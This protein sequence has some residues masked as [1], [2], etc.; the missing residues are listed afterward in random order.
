MKSITVPHSIGDFTIPRPEPKSAD[1][2]P[3]RK[4]LRKYIKDATR[5]NS[6]SS[7]PGREKVIQT[8]LNRHKRY[9]LACILGTSDSLFSDDD[10][11]LLPEVL[12]L[13]G[14]EHG[15]NGLYQLL[16]EVVPYLMSSSSA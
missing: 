8:Q 12:A 3:T 2:T 10:A 6:N 16:I 7:N 5:I 1:D 11:F 9:E 13:V 15:Q 4:E 14:K